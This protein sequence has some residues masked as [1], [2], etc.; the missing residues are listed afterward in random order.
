[1][2]AVLERTETPQLS[3][4]LTMTDEIR[5]KLREGEGAV[6]VADAYTIDCTEMAEAAATEMNT[7]K[8]AIVKLEDLRRGFTA[9]AQ[10]IIDNARALFNPAIDGYKR[11]EFMLKE[12]LGAW[13]TQERNRIALENK[14][15]EEAAR[16]I[17]QEAEEKARAE[18]AKARQIAADKQ[19]LAD[20]QEALRVKA[21]AE[22]NQRTAAAIAKKKAKLDQ[23]AASAIENGAAKAEQ[24]HLEAAAA[25]TEAAPV[26]QAK[27]V[28]ATMAVNWIAERKPNITEA[29]AKK[30]IVAATVTNPMLLG[31][32]DIN[33]GAL[34][35]LAKG[36]HEAF[37]VPGYIAVKDFQVRGK[38]K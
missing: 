21:E 29:E 18:E 19:R 27:V 20:E 36:L 34:N 7:C 23:Q 38:R 37:D 32:I 15:R 9:P 24:A 14:Q 1:M 26:A 16:K 22:G 28:G 35:K 30:L 33:E 17:R 3:V 12:R 6:V 5:A 25:T 31:V 4:T 8:R 11:A 13:D 10:T 2:S